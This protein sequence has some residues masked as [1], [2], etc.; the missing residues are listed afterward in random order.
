MRRIRLGQPHEIG[1]ATGDLYRDDSLLAAVC[2]LSDRGDHDLVYQ[3]ADAF[4]R[5]RGVGIGSGQGGSAQGVGA[6]AGPG[7][8]INTTGSVQDMETHGEYSTT[9]VIAAGPIAVGFDA[10][11]KGFSLDPKHLK[12]FRPQS[13]IKTLKNL[14]PKK[15]GEKGGGLFGGA[16]YTKTTS[17]TIRDLFHL[18]FGQSK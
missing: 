6:V 15:L 13:M 18:I 17:F 2:F 16:T 11:K 10:G 14:T 8:T 9:V 12:V 5:L 1:P 7:L 3:G 4:A